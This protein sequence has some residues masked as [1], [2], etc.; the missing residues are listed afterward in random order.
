[1]NQDNISKKAKSLIGKN[2]LY[3]VTRKGNQ[4]LTSVI[5]E[6]VKFIPSILKVGKSEYTAIR[7]KMRPT[8]KK[9]SRAFWSTT[10]ADKK[11]NP[12]PRKRKK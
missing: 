12:Q 2:Q 3:E 10:F 9:K 8:T 7:F 1:M 11:I 5:I 6:D 4:V